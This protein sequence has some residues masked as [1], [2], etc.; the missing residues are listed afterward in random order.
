M[1]EL[2]GVKIQRFP[3]TSEKYL[4]KQGI[5]SCSNYFHNGNSSN[6]GGLELI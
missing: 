6:G 3:K 4:R 5:K 1:S 2:F